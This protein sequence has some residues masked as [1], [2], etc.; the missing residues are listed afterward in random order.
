MKD[1]F[2]I[3]DLI[4]NDYK[5]D[6]RNKTYATEELILASILEE[7]GE[8]ISAASLHGLIDQ[9]QSGELSSIDEEKYDAASYRCGVLAR[10][11]FA[12]DPEDEDAEVDYEIF[13][14]VNDDNSISAEIQMM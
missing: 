12:E 1:M 11:C 10:K 14:L 2:E 13:W 4:A 8:L 9:Y 3:S 5:K 7:T 6:P